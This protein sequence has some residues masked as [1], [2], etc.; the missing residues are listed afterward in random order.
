MSKDEAL[1]FDANLGRNEEYTTTEVY[2]GV[3]RDGYDPTAHGYV[4]FPHSTETLDEFFF[5]ESWT[6]TQRNGSSL[7]NESIAIRAYGLDPSRSQFACRFT[8]RQD[9]QLVVYSS[10]TQPTGPSELS[11]VTPPW[12]T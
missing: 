6:G 7:G 1:E 3:S 8:S 12:G 10:T 5:F 2:T 9:S 4:V 11:C